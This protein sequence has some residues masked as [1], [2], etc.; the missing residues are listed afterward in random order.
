MISI[1]INRSN[2][3]DTTMFSDL[4]NTNGSVLVPGN[5]T[6]LLQ[7]NV[8]SN[9]T[10]PYEPPVEIVV[11]LSMFYGAISL[12]AVLGKSIKTCVSQF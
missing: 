9:H 6:S 11:L 12:V 2:G 7:N 5:E 4:E 1:S 3:T 10:S 8:T